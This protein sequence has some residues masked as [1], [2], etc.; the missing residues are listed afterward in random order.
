MI[1]DTEKAKDAN[2]QR[3]DAL[4]LLVG[5][6]KLF[7][8]PCKI[9]KMSIKFN[10]FPQT[11]STWRDL[12][13]GHLACITVYLLGNMNTSTISCTVQLDWHTDYILH[14]SWVKP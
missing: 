12:G 9:I 11:K 2:K 4:C 5:S 1:S 3:E 8:G 13:F 10:N 14:I 7:G 6:F